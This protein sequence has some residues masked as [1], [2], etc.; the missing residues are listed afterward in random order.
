[1]I[2]RK[3][4][5]QQFLN[6]SLGWKIT[7]THQHSAA[8]KQSPIIVRS[9]PPSRYAKTFSRK[10][11]V[12]SVM[13]EAVVAWNICDELKE[14]ALWLSQIASQQQSSPKCRVQINCNRICLW[15]TCP[16]NGL[17][18]SCLLTAQ[19][20]IKVWFRASSSMQATGIDLQFIKD[21]DIYKQVRILRIL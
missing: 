12:M 19:L 16:R 8:I 2:S 18:I 5:H 20:Y 7:G 6:N 15:S 17:R 1:M 13:D 9:C 4:L 3:N 11:S 21:T 14:C 10:A